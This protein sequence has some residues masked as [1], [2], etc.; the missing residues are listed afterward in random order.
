MKKRNLEIVFK[1]LIN[2]CIWK[3]GTKYF[4]IRDY[5]IKI[6]LLHLMKK[7]GLADPGILEKQLISSVVLTLNDVLDIGRMI[8]FMY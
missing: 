5:A 6:I 4:G 3:I 7:T 1:H 2:S 8:Y